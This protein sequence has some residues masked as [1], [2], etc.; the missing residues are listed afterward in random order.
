MGL[1]L[2]FVEECSLGFVPNTRHVFCRQQA[3]LAAGLFCF[4]LVDF[5]LFLKFLFRQSVPR[6]KS[7]KL[8]VPTLEHQ[9]DLL[10]GPVVHRNA[11]NLRHRNAHAPVLATALDTDQSAV[12]DRRPLGIPSIAIDAIP[13]AGKGVQQPL[14]GGRKG[15]SVGRRIRVAGV[16]F[17]TLQHFSE[18]GVSS[19]GKVQ[20]FFHVGFSRRLGSAVAASQLGVVGNLVN[21]SVSKVSQ[22]RS[23]S[24]FPR[25]V[26]AFFIEL[27]TAQWLTGIGI[28]ELV[29]LE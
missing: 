12:A 8:R 11:P 26:F 19:I 7:P 10:V 4:S 13:V 20:L 2:V 16:G 1:Q 5:F 9:D 6:E 28:V 15:L 3:G 22:R 14:A 27:V 24:S 25:T 17:A 21:G 18:F 29:S 23:H